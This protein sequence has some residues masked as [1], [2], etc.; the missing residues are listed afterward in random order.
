MSTEQT[1]FNCPFHYRYFVIPSGPNTLSS[2]SLQ[3]KLNGH[4]SSG[5]VLDFNFVVGSSDPTSRLALF[6]FA[7][8]YRLENASLLAGIVWYRVLYH[9]VVIRQDKLITQ[10]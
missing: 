2:R 7:K 1:L 5:R 9:S 6:C 4:G 3:G 10:V 8:K